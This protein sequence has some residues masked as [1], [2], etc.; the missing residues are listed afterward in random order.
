MKDCQ[1]VL[2]ELIKKYLHPSYQ[3]KI[4]AE[5]D[6]LQ[7]YSEAEMQNVIAVAWISIKTLQEYGMFTVGNNK[8]IQMLVMRWF[9]MSNMNF[10]RYKEYQTAIQHLS[11][12]FAS[13]HL[14]MMIM[15]GYGCS[16]NYPYPECRPCGDIDVWM[17][18]KQKIADQLVRKNLDLYVDDNN[19]HHSVFQYESFTVEN[20]GTIQDINI[21]KS[22]VYV[23]TI[24]EKLASEEQHETEINGVKIQLPSAKFNSIHLLRHMACDFATFTT[25]LRHVLDWSTFVSNNVNNI[26]WAFIRSVA[27]KANMHK[28]LDAI[29]GICV[30]YLGYPKDMFP[31]EKIDYKLRDRVLFD[32]LNNHA[33]PDIPKPNLSFFQK[34]Q[35]GLYKT[36]RMWKNRWKYQIVYDESFLQSFLTLTLNRIKN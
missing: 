17:F 27:H 23:N 2:L 35:Y 18:G 28:F 12:F 31:V 10:Q 20:H 21:H 36:S 3:I 30:E 25:T 32:I 6:W 16:L 15:K 1:I 22:D 19:E 29:N 9:G 5:A 4:P 24:L 33:K 13:N 11:R 34:I 8:S 7:V 14:K 26:D